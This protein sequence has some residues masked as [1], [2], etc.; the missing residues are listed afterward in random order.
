[1]NDQTYYSVPEY[2]YHSTNYRHYLVGY[3]GDIRSEFAGIEGMYVDLIND[4]YGIL[5]V[6]ADLT[7]VDMNVNYLI[8]IMAGFGRE[9]TTVTYIRPTDLYTLEQI[10]PRDAAQVDFLQ[11]N[12]PLNLTGDGVIIGIIDTGIDYLNK[13]FMNRDGQ[14]RIDFIW[15]Q[16]IYNEKNDISKMSTGNREIPYGVIYGKEDI[17]RAINASNNGGN[18]YDIVPSKDE[19]G[20]GTN[21]A[22]LVGGT[23]INRELIG[24]APNCRFAIIKLL[25][26]ISVKYAYD[27]ETPVYNITELFTAIEYLKD[28][29]IRLGI[30]MVIFLPL[31]SNSGDHRGSSILDQYL[32]SVLNNIGI[33]AVTGSGNEGLSQ[34]H[35]SGVIQ[36]V[37]DFENVELIVSKGERFIVAEVWVNVP[38]IMYINIISPSGEDTGMINALINSTEEYTFILEKTTVNVYYYIPEELSGQQLIKL[39]FY[40]VQEGTWK[41][42]LT[43]KSGQNARYDIWIQQSGLKNEGTRFN[44]SDPYGTIMIP[45][46]SLDVITVAAYNQNNNNIVNT[47]GIAFKDKF[48]EVIDVAAGGVNALATGPNNKIDIING[49][50]VSAAIVAGICAAML[51]WGIIDKNFPSLYCQSMKTFLVR[52]TRKRRGDIYPNPQWGH[53]TINAFEIFNNLS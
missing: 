5:L 16:S 26:S 35:A 31:G 17:Q 33:V 47:S 21:M 9:L 45:G 20:H 49:T 18:P 3:Q 48:L 32:T 14:T 19:I 28:Y 22:G 42:R 4:R 10:S 46:D 23:G 37:N 8:D 44:P 53:G 13:E 1:M 24:V 50:S 6:R 15:D 7:R 43:L 2:L 34:S 25:E 36:K 38:N 52:G 11:V 39:Y 40:N 30:P 12:K 27:I 51:Q 41:F 29:S